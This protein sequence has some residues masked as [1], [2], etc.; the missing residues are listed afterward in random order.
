MIQHPRERRHPVGT[1]RLLRAGLEN[2]SVH[3]SGPNE[4]GFASLAGEI[5]PAAGLLF[6][7]R[8]GRALSKLSKEDRPTDL[9]V[10]DGTWGQ[11]RALFRHSPWMAELPR[12]S[13]DPI[14]PSR[15]RIRKE[16]RLECVSTLEAVVYALQALEPELANLGELI[17]AFDR[18]IDAAIESRGHN[19][20]LA[21]R[22]RGAGGRPSMTFAPALLVPRR[23][24][25]LVHV[26]VFSRTVD[27]R[28]KREPLVW[29]AL[30]VGTGEARRWHL[31]PERLNDASYLHTVMGID[32]SDLPDRIGRDL[33]QSEW[34]AWLN[35]DDAI[36]AWSPWQLELV[37]HGDHLVAD[38]KGAYC[39]LVQRKAGHLAEV[40]A[41]HGLEVPPVSLPGR[42]GQRLAQLEV[43]MD[44]IRRSV[45][46]RFPQSAGSLGDP[47]EAGTRH[48]PG[49][50]QPP[51]TI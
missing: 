8:G 2:I 30:R 16:P 41:K 9:V 38:I 51:R 49:I 50:G 20:R 17:P 25:V 40:P 12:F 32:A 26:D 11:A 37:S 14:E 1:V 4:A 45:S 18:M 39:S 33:F 6:P 13:I 28:K 48:R 5:P 35:P 42:A 3:V 24:L 44:L 7:G 21:S 22:P 43:V 29:S 31:G 47:V 27:G 23:D 34:L 19:P 46:V 10:L 36:A 15:Y